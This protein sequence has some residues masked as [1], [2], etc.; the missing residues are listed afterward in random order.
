MKILFILLLAIPLVASAQEWQGEFMAGVAGYN[1]DLTQHRVNIDE[2]RP[3]GGLNIKYNSGDFVNMRFGLAYARIGAADKYNSSQLLKD[4]N[5]SFVSNIAEIN[6]IV[7]INLADPETYSSYPY[8][9]GGVGVFHFNPFTTDDQGKKVFLRPLS[10]EGEGLKEYPDRKEYALTQV[11]IPVGIGWKIQLKEKWYMSIEF[12]Y[13]ITFTDYLDD[14]S[15]NYVSLSVLA[16]EKGPEAAALS[17]RGKG[18]LTAA[19]I[20]GNPGNKDV[21]YFGG[22]KIGTSL[23]NLFGRRKIKY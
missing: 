2:L 1:G 9:L 17:Y 6:A 5:L 23:R 20:R 14:V 10:T 11:C 18:P 8:V 7:E 21:Y 3:S 13:R 19:D 16:A 4:R 22:L 12:G 15:T